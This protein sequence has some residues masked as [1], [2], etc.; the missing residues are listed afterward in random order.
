[1]NE[2]KKIPPD[3]VEVGTIGIS[4][5]K[6]YLNAGSSFLFRIL[7]L[8]M[9]VVAQSITNGSDYWLIKWLYNK[10]IYTKNVNNVEN[11]KFNSTIFNNSED[12]GLYYS[13]KYNVYVYFG[14]ICVVLFTMILSGLLLYN[15]FIAASLKLHKN[16]FQCII[17]TP[18]S[19]LDKI[20]VGNVLNRFSKDVNNVD[21]ILPNNAHQ[22][23]KVSLH[24][25]I[26]LNLC[27]MNLK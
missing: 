1:E 13:D 25:F 15:F 7:L 18:I 16:M 3:D 4:V 10:R 12:Q 20:P 19:F 26:Y 8:L 22:L 23:L 5:Y 11:L 21:D 14:L 2:N 17:R 6:E 24:N 9:L 27:K